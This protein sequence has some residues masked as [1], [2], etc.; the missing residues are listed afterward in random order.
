MQLKLNLLFLLCLFF[1]ACIGNPAV[2]TSDNDQVQQFLSTLPAADGLVFI[3]VAGRRVNQN[4]TLRLALENAAQ[5]VSMFHRVSG[6]YILENTI[7]SGFLDWTHDVRS[8]LA[9]DV[10][11]SARYLDLL[12]FDIDNDTMLFRNAFFVRT[13]VQMTLPSPVNFLPSYGADGRPDWI[14]SIPIIDGYEVGVGFSARRASMAETFNNSRNN[15]IFSIIKNISATARSSNIQS[16]RSDSIF[17][18][19]AITDHSIHAYGT[20]SSF[21]VLDTWIDQ[22]TWQ[23]W[24]LAIAKQSQ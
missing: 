5:R 8:A 4:E 13:F 24:T 17:A 18:F 20:L 23:V 9:F 11:G 1:I 10:D 19:D 6:E 15:A 2:N 21:Y 16:Y 3:G 14:N 7:G 12:Q 22:R